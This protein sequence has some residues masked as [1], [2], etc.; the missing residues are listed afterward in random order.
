MRMALPS[1]ARPSRHHWPGGREREQVGDARRGAGRLCHTQAVGVPCAS[2]VRRS[3]EKRDGLP[4]VLR[5]ANIC[6]PASCGSS[7]HMYS[8]HNDAFQCWILPSVRV[9]QKNVLLLPTDCRVA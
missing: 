3:D 2:R 6:G 8:Q 4:G 7:L 9:P 5:T 1:L